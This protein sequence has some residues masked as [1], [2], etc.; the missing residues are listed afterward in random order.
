MTGL[1]A[2]ICGCC[3]EEESTRG[4]VRGMI[5]WCDDRRWC[6]TCLKCERHCAC[7]RKGEDLWPDIL[8]ASRIS[9]D[10]NIRNIDLNRVLDQRRRKLDRD[11]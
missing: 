6:A 3:G 9:I 1:C 7:E 5:C 8:T 4:C 11:M 10:R 2:R